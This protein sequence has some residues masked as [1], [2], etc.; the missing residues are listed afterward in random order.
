M[1]YLNLIFFKKSTLDNKNIFK[2]KL[3]FEARLFKIND[4]ISIKVCKFFLGE[5]FVILNNYYY[6]MENTF[7]L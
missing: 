4:N 7:S 1:T 3:Y 5:K 2:S 6:I